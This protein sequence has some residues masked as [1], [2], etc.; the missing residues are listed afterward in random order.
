MGGK[1]ELGQAF[2]FGPF[3]IDQFEFHRHIRNFEK[4]G[5]QSTSSGI[6]ITTQVPHHT[7]MLPE[8]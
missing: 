8:A 7:I 4:A 3:G 1:V 6:E 5:N 2:K